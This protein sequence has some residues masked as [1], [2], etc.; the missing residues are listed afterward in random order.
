M[1]RINDVGGMQGFGPVQQ[2]LD[3]PAFHSDW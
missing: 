2:E 3:E 1:A